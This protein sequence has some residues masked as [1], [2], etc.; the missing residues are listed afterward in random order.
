MIE[1]QQLR[2]ELRSLILV[3]CYL[4]IV[5][6][7][8]KAFGLFDVVVSFLGVAMG[9][10]CAVGSLYIN[11]L[12]RPKAK[13]RPDLLGQEL[14]RCCAKRDEAAAVL[15]RAMAFERELQ[16]SGS[17]VPEGLTQTIDRAREI[18]TV[19]LARIEA[20]R[21]QSAEERHNAE[22]SEIKRLAQELDGTDV[23]LRPAGGPDPSRD[24]SL[25]LGRPVE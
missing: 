2:L 7:L 19:L 24:Q 10:V 3:S 20:L 1:E 14:S 21:R 6:S 25:R 15:A 16:N 13:M 23:L 18:E 4:V 5:A 22:L 9:E 11:L 17:P 8:G 12:R